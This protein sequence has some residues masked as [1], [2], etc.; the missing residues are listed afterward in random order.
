LFDVFA[1]MAAA[2]I[3]GCKVAVSIPRGM[4]TPAV[5]FLANEHGKAMTRGVEVVHQ[6]DSELIGTMR[7]TQR[8][9]YAAPERVSQEVFEAAART[10]FTIVRSPVLMEGRIELLHYFQQQSVCDTYHR[11]GNLGERTV[12]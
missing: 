8:I 5:K 11:Y 2:I 4:D 9:R 12:I 10:G 3:S 6:N 1:R 7:S